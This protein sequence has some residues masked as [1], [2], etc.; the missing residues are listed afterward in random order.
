[1]QAK[2]NDSQKVPPQVKILVLMLSHN[3]MNYIK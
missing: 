3:P 2:S 1:M